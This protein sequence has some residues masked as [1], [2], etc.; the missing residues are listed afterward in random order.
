[1]IKNILILTTINLLNICKKH[2]EEMDNINK[3]LLLEEKNKLIDL[4]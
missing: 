4:L 2:E 1:L 3:E